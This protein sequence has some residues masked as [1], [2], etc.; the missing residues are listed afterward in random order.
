MLILLDKEGV[1]RYS[2]LLAHG[3]RS[4]FDGYG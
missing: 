2:A 3:G 4:G 1:E